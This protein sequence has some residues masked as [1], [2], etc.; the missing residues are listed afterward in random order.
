MRGVV[1]L[2][3]ILALP[4][5][6]LQVQAQDVDVTGSWVLSLEDSDFGNTRAP[7]AA[8]L[9][10]RRADT[11]LTLTSSRDYGT[12]PESVEI[13]IPI[14]GSRHSVATPRGS[15]LMSAEWDGDVLEIWRRA[16]A[17][18]GEVDITERCYVEE[19]GKRLRVASSIEVPQT[20]AFESTMIFVRANG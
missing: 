11:R 20:G 5:A 19:E 12:G 9:A 8:D 18:V 14:D 15:M 3:A 6:G 13:D 16:E 4:F 2:I 17:N 1:A 7:E 10:I